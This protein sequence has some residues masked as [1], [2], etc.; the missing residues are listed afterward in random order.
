VSATSGRHPTVRFDLQDGS[1]PEDI[2]RGWS[3]AI[4]PVDLDDDLLPEIYIANDFGPDRLLHNR[5]TPGHFQ[6]VPLQETR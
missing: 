2:S 5:S 4:G 1:I 3:Y 6:F